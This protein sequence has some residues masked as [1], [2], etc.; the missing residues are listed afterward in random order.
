MMLTLF[1]N[2][3]AANKVIF[4]ENF[5][6]QWGILQENLQ[7]KFNF[8]TTLH[9]Q[10]AHNNVISMD[11]YNILNTLCIR[12]NFEHYNGWQTALC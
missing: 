3:F 9:P 6:H 8:N 4:K 1:F 7:L 2:A 11:L 10:C 12:K 5:V